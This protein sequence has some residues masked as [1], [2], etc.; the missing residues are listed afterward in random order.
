[1]LGGIDLRTIAA[2]VYRALS[3][4]GL[5][6]GTLTVSGSSSLGGTL[7]LTGEST[8]SQITGNQNDY[9]PTGITTSSVLR[10]SSDARRSLTG[11][12]GGAAG[13][14]IVLH[15]VGTFPIVFKFQDGA[16]SAANRF[17][18]GHTLS[19]GHS[20]TIVYD[21]TTARWRCT[22]KE[23]L[24]G[25]IKPFGGGTVPDGYL[26]RDGSNVSRAT[27]AALF[28]EIGTTWGVG[29]GA[30][31]FGV[32]DDRRRSW[33]G[34]GGSGTG[35]LGNA[36]GNTGGEESH[37]LTSGENGPHAHVEQ[38]ASA[39]GGGGDVVNTASNNFPNSVTEQ[40]STASSG[41][42]TAHNTYHPAAVVTSIIKF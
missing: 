42:G 8:P 33:V 25:T 14:T 17:A 3:S 6:L 2:H 18:F 1:M 30:T 40:S 15:N 27:Y 23:D 41:S 36:V 16:S 39:G 11:L 10:L 19:G 31:T 20:M 37:A 35:T 38:G 5:A 22:A 7:S 26:G 34:S 4:V 28:N 29:D 12:Q 32:G 24:A 9:N 21:T 13:R